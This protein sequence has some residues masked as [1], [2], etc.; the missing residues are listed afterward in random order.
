VSIDYGV[1]EKSGRIAVVPADFGWSD[2]GSFDALPE[3][4]RAD[5]RGNV[6][7]GEAIVIDGRDNVVLGRKDRPLALIGLDGVVAVDAGD[8]ILVVKRDRSQDVRKAVEELK[9]RG[10]ERWL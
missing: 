7:E 6:V 2:V 9:R 1:M 3:V 5:E 8:A 4:R 10:L